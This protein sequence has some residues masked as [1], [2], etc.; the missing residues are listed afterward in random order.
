MM[1]NNVIKRVCKCEKESGI[2]CRYRSSK[3]FCHEIVLLSKPVD[4]T[5]LEY[6]KKG[7]PNKVILPHINSSMKETKRGMKN[8]F[9][10]V[11]K[12]E[13]FNLSFRRNKRNYSKPISIKRKK[14]N[15]KIRYTSRINQGAE[16]VILLNN[17]T[18]TNN[19]FR[20][21]NISCFNSSSVEKI[22]IRRFTHTTNILLKNGDLMKISKLNIIELLDYVNKIL[23]KNDDTKIWDNIFIQIDKLISKKKKNEYNDEI[24][25]FFQK[26]NNFDYYTILNNLKYVDENT[27][28]EIL[29][30]AFFEC[31]VLN[32]RNRNITYYYGNDQKV[33]DYGLENL[34]KNDTQND[35]KKNVRLIKKWLILS[36]SFSNN[37]ENMVMLKDYLN[38]IFRQ[39][40]DKLIEIDYF[41]KTTKYLENQMNSKTM[42]SIIFT[43]ENKLELMKPYDLSFSLFILQKFLILNYNL[44]NK[45]VDYIV[46]SP[47]N[48]FQTHKNFINFIK[49]VES[50]V[51]GPPQ[52]L[53]KPIQD[54]INLYHID[55]KNKSE[56]NIA[57]SEHFQNNMNNF[58]N[59]CFLIFIKKISLIMHNYNL[60]NLLFL[61]ECMQNIIFM[62][63]TQN[64][65]MNMFINKLRH[66]INKCINMDTADNYTLTRIYKIYS[67][68]SFVPEIEFSSQPPFNDCKINQE[69]SYANIEDDNN[70]S[71]SV[72]NNIVAS[73]LDEQKKIINKSETNSENKN[74]SKDSGDTIFNKKDDINNLNTFIRDW[75]L[76][77]V[78]D[79][80]ININKDLLNY[81]KNYDISSR[82]NL[83][84]NVVA[85]LCSRMNKNLDEIKIELNKIKKSDPNRINMLFPDKKD[86][87]FSFVKSDI[88]LDLLT[89]EIKKI[90]DN[91]VDKDM[92]KESFKNDLQNEYL[93]FYNIKVLSDIFKFSQFSV[94][95]NSYT[96]DIIKCIKKK[97]DEIAIL[98]SIDKSEMIEKDESGWNEKNNSKS[99]GEI[100]KIDKDK[101]CNEIK[102][103]SLFHLY[104]FYSSCKNYSP[105]FILKFVDSLIK[106][107]PKMNIVNLDNNS[108]ISFNEKDICKT[109]YAKLY[110]EVTKNKIIN[111]T[112]IP[113]VVPLLQT[114]QIII[115]SNLFLKN[116]TLNEYINIMAQYSYFVL[117][118]Y[119]YNSNKYEGKIENPGENVKNNTH[120]EKQMTN[121]LKTDKSNTDY[122]EIDGYNNENDVFK[123]RGNIIDSHK[124]YR[125]K[126]CIF[127]N[128]YLEDIWDIYTCLSTCLHFLNKTEEKTNGIQHLTHLENHFFKIISEKKYMKYLSDNF[129]FYLFKTPSTNKLEETFDNAISSLKIDNLKKNINK[130][131]ESISSVN[132]K[133]LSLPS[134]TAFFLCKIKLAMQCNNM[135]NP[136]NNERVENCKKLFEILIHD[137]KMLENYIENLFTSHN[138]PDQNMNVHNNSTQIFSWTEGKNKRNGKE[139]MLNNFSNKT[140]YY[141]LPYLVSNKVCVNKNIYFKTLISDMFFGAHQIKTLYNLQNTLLKTVKYIETTQIN[142]NI[143]Y[144]LKEMQP[145]H[146]NI[147]SY[148]LELSNVVKSC[149]Y[150]TIL[151]QPY[152]HKSPKKYVTKGLVNYFINNCKLSND[153]NICEKNNPKLINGVRNY[154]YMVSKLHS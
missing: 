115:S 106:I 153:G 76:I 105:T 48:K 140:K 79:K 22:Q 107:T 139:N 131:D 122:A 89:S 70:E 25:L 58:Y 67:V 10:G 86:T 47:L 18:K 1:K 42:H 129:V 109:E 75:D 55:N 81:N 12:Y 99:L 37:S 5:C 123:N 152:I 101:I 23:E 13:L 71:I 117:F 38:K 73:E 51:I 95:T 14:S 24:D 72:K 36:A 130:N 150:S 27:K 132:E 60:E 118:Y 17:G 88:N 154:K 84:K 63:S 136:E 62:A 7:I 43:Y 149:L 128:L 56:N 102:N 54:N 45:I 145:F 120:E 34:Q 77:Q 66:N 68:F 112:I 135:D 100:Y 8:I 46:C 15:E 30:G 53:G 85:V 137:Y 110:D 26:L 64:Q 114:I 133:V 3:H 142:I 134:S 50:F 96:Y 141:Y 52:T 146:N 121:N 94:N 119:Y 20:L 90:N 82:N 108:V 35:E 83:L 125:K 11:K 6:E 91:N 49:S 148:L 87:M 28:N 29:K 103:I 147:L 93:I 78:Y 19:I 9:D 31:F 97:L 33:S 127:E 104:N 65:I 44:F 111:T 74:I 143:N 116:N 138:N 151:S 92:H 69:H 41:A 4:A 59:T 40:I 61:S 39:N 2:I 124:N 80:T 144:K 113:F 57:C 21:N 32:L 16:K 126:I 98:Y